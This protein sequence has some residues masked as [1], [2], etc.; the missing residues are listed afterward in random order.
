M[1]SHTSSTFLSL[2]AELICHVL[3]FL[4]PQDLAVLSA[5]SH[6]LHTHG[7]TEALWA[8]HVRCSVPTTVASPSPCPTWRELYIAHHPFWFLP[9]CKLWF[10]DRDLGGNTL[11]GCLILAR[12]DSRR[13]CIEAY[14][15]VAQ[16]GKH[17]FESWDWKPDVIIHTFNPKVALHLDDPVVQLVYDPEPRTG[18]YRSRVKEESTMRTGRVTSNKISL[19]HAMPPA[20]QH[21]SMNLW[22]PSTF[23]AK[24]RVRCESNTMFRN[25]A[26]KPRSLAQASDQS[27][28]IRKYLDLHGMERHLGIGHLGARLGEDVLTFST[29][30]EES[31]TPTKEKPWQGIFVGDYR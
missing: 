17:T 10:A 11:T 22:P 31:Y 4:P 15:L 20:L 9:R 19:C 29:L 25:T 13:G 26:H 24:H 12:Y 8:A 30:L 18:K 7:Q 1:T 14:S 21:P 23:P 28:R 16:H 27:F 6:L 5:T 3:G 2:P